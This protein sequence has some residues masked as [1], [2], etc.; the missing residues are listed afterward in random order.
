VGPVVE[1]FRAH[2]DTLG[3]VMVVP[4]HYTN[5]SPELSG[6]RR[7]QVHSMDP[8]PFAL[9]NGRDRDAVERFGEEP[10]LGGRYASAGLT[11]LDLLALLGAVPA[12]PLPREVVP[13]GGVSLPGGV[14]AR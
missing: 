5:S 14:P 6:S 3:G 13:L 12:R 4:D 9:W 1:H 8:V 7:A 11:H 10:A 2:P